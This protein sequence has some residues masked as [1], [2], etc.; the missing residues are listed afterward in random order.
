MSLA[1]LP[2]AA[3]EAPGAAE[4]AVRAA[5]PGVIVNEETGDYTAIELE[6]QGCRSC[7]A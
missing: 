7:S 5:S 6:L 1:A 2:A 4:L 3:Q